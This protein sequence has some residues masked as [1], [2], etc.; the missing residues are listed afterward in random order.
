MN[1]LVESMN[2]E[3]PLLDAEMMDIPTSPEIHDG[4]AT[5]SHDGRKMFFTRWTKNNDQTISYIYTSRWENKGWTTPVKAPEPLN[6]EGSNSAQPSLTTDG[7]FILFASDRPGGFGEIYDIWAS[8][9][10]YKF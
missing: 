3:N 8:F 7:R 9:Y 6:V 10:E 4:M 2:S 5:F 1:T